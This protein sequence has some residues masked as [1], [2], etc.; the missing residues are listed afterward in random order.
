MLSR[1]DHVGLE[2]LH[3]GFRWTTVDPFIVT[4][5]HLDHFPA[6]NAD[7]GGSAYPVVGSNRVHHGP[8]VCAPVN[9]PRARVR[10]AD[11]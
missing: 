11:T 7:R 9:G 3:L 2:T 8:T 1:P 6:G 4:V 10:G 5:H